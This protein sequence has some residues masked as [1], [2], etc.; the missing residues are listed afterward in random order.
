MKIKICGLQTTEDIKCVNETLPNYAGFIF[1]SKSKRKIS[2]EQALLLKK[3][4]SPKIKSVGV[5]ADEYIEKIIEYANMN[6]TDLI[7]LH[8]NEDNAYIKT[9]KQKIKIPIIKALKADNNLEKNTKECIADYIL[10]DSNSKEEFGGTGKTFDWNL[11][12]KTEKKIFL[13]GGLNEKNIINAI[14][15]V[16]PYCLDINSGVETNGKKDREKIINIMNKIKGYIN[17]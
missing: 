3:E 17:E 15:E 13:A 5:F 1:V 14:K 2:I 4:L 9:L 6:I 7:Q 11:I 8:G 12:P 16:N 10:I